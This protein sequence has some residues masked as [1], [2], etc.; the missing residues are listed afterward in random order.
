M[1]I[2]E[3]LIS[4]ERTEF[5]KYFSYLLLELVLLPIGLH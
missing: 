3:A 4:C 2:N 1:K 5:Y